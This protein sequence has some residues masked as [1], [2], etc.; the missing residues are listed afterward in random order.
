M[1]PWCSADRSTLL[2]WSITTTPVGYVPQF[3]AKYIFQI[4]TSVYIEPYEALESWVGPQFKPIAYSL[5]LLRPDGY[6]CVFLGDLEVIIEMI[7][8]RLTLGQLIH[9]WLP[10]KTGHQRRTQ[11]WT[12]ESVRWFDSRS[13][14]FCVWSHEGLLG[15]WAMRGMDQRRWW[16]P[17]WM[18]GCDLEWG[19]RDQTYGSWKG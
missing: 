19:R 7:L 3:Q 1:T 5:I 17:W 11:I 14:A 18:R 15:P 4:L 12:G 2:R 6:P 13:K 8:Q 9:V 16:P 10:P